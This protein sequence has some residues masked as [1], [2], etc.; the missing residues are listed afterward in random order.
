MTQDTAGQIRLPQSI[1]IYVTN[2]IIDKSIGGFLMKAIKKD[3]PE[4]LMKKATLTAWTRLLLKQG[5]ID[6][7]KCNKMLAAIERLTA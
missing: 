5:K 1:R 6:I 7:T 4:L 3:S 2:H